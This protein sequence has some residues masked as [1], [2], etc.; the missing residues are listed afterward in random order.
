VL[1]PAD[2]RALVA[3]VEGAPLPRVRVPRPRRPAA[4]RV[5]RLA[6]R[7]R[8][9]GA[10]P[11]RS[12]APVPPRRPRRAAAFAGVAPDHLAQALVTEY[13]AGAAIGWH[14]DKAVFG[15]VVG[16]SLL[17]PCTF[18]LRRAAPGGG[19]ERRALVAE[20]RSAYLLRG[21]ARAEWE[22]SIPAVPALRYSV[23][24]RSLRARR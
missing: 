2:E 9:R 3:A 8:R 15:D 16:L 11:G 4:C 7:L 22:H 10:P 21:P 5:V 18:R 6:V 24:F 19:W 12:P 17:A 14:R 20:P 23:T 13:D 1:S